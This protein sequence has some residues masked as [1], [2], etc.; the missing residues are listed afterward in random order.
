MGSCHNID[1]EIG[2]TDKSLFFIIPIHAK[3]EG[4]VILE[5]E[6]KRFCYLDIIKDGF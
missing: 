5:K 3:E 4:K 1:V 6:M 2:V